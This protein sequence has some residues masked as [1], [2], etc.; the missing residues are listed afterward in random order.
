MYGITADEL[1]ANVIDD[2]R[3]FARH[4]GFDISRI[5]SGDE[6]PLEQTIRIVMWLFL[7]HECQKT[8]KPT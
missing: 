5:G 7:E 3:A 2:L 6:R 1:H 4:H 8:M